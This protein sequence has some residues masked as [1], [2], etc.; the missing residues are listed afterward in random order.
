MAHADITPSKLL[1]P[2]TPCQLLK[3]QERRRKFTLYIRCCRPPVAAI[4]AS[5][6]DTNG[7][8]FSLHEL[9]TIYS[10]VPFC[11]STYSNRLQ[12]LPKRCQYVTSVEDY[13]RQ[14]C[15]SLE[16]HF[17][18]SLQNRPHLWTVSVGNRS[19]EVGREAVLEG[20]VTTTSLWNYLQLLS[21]SS[22]QLSC[23]CSAHCALSPSLYSMP[24]ETIFAALLT[25]KGHTATAT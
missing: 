13:R 12:K 20:P 2:P 22:S 24:H 4:W 3:F 21:S 11:I 7:N 9:K 18:F 17:S 16:H 6:H 5:T 25:A 14:Y 10:A 19:L 15:Q 23:Q 8:R 1:Q